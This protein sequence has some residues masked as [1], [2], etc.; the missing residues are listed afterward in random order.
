MHGRHHMCR[1]NSR[2]F[3]SDRDAIL[4]GKIDYKNIPTVDCWVATHL[5]E[6]YQRRILVKL[7][8]V[9]DNSS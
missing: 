4:D 7:S 1:I 2:M 9:T 6:I 5:K 8:I 3:V